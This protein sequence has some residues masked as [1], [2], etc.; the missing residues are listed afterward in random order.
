M[1]LSPNPAVQQVDSLQVAAAGDAPATAPRL[2]RR[3]LQ[4]PPTNATN[5]LPHA[6]GPGQVLLSRC[7]IEGLYSKPFDQSIV[8]AK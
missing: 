2:P 4:T 1:G 7:E 3:A 8:C 5:L 6:L